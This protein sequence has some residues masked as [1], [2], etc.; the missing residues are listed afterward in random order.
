MQ[1]I[2]NLVTDLMDLEG[3]LEHYLLLAHEIE[4][5]ILLIERDLLKM[6]FDSVKTGTVKRKLRN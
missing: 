5:Q 1:D 6:G 2:E 3:L 4:R